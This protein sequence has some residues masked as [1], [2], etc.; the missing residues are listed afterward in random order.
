MRLLR[1][2]PYEE[3]HEKLELI[4]VFGQDAPKYAILSHTWGRD[5]VTLDHVLSGTAREHEAYDKVINAIQEAASDGLEYI[6]IDSCCID[7]SSSAE[8]SESI[9]SMYAWYER[10][11]ICYAILEDVPGILAVDFRAKFKSS[12]W[13][14]RGWTLQELLAPKRVL[15]FGRSVCGG[16]TPPLGDRTT[17]AK[18]ISE[19]TSIE[20][21]YLT[22]LKSVYRAS[23]AKRMS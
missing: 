2:G 11:E 22:G 1:T 10:S 7:K 4:E 12:R 17:L 6:W 19:I 16:W 13:F 5:E 9:N 15:L 14:T 20:V 8:L 3:G 21:D 18:S 23:I